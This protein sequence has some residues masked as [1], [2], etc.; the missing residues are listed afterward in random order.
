MFL[1]GKILPIIALHADSYLYARRL[2]FPV[3]LARR[4]DLLFPSVSFGA[5]TLTRSVFRFLHIETFSGIDPHL[6]A[7]FAALFP[8]VMSGGAAFSACPPVP[9]RFLEK[10][11]LRLTRAHTVFAGRNAVWHCAAHRQ[12][13]ACHLCRTSPYNIS[14][15]QKL[16]RTFRRGKIR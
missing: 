10:R 13:P 12:A 7:V 1:Q 4:S 14:A 6:Q 8:Q 2:L 11:Y 3:P 15:V 5:V 16:R 9:P